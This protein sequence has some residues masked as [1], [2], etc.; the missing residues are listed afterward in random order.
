MRSNT[1]NFKEAF[2]I[3]DKYVGLNVS[4]QVI[5]EMKQDIK[6]TLMNTE[7]TVSD[8]QGSL[9]LAAVL[10]ANLCT[11]VGLDMDGTKLSVS[12][13]ETEVASKSIAELIELWRVLAGRVEPTVSKLADDQPE[14]ALDIAQEN[15]TNT[16][17]GGYIQ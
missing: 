13:D 17:S 15:P 5:H 11:Q 14:T 8:L 7:P 1:H 12:I 9:A 16:D 3:L 10:L 2:G 4:P 6:E